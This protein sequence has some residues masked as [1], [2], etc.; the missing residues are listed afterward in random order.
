MTISLLTWEHRPAVADFAAR[1][2]WFI[3]TFQIRWKQIPPGDPHGSIADMRLT[4]GVLD[5]FRFWRR[6]GPVLRTLP[7]EAFDGRRDYE[8]PT[9]DAE[10]YGPWRAPRLL[11]RGQPPVDLG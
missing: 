10:R 4:A 2:A 5:E 9:W 6:F 3:P 1:E 7:A 8:V 11:R